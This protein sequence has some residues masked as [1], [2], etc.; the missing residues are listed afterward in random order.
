[1]MKTFSLW[2][3]SLLTALAS[4]GPEREFLIAAIEKWF[5]LMALVEFTIF[6]C[7]QLFI[8]EAQC[9]QIGYFLPSIYFLLVG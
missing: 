6:L 8:R 9:F 3:Q 1:M 5:L 4:T 2:Y 7:E